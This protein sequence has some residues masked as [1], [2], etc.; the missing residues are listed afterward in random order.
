MIINDDGTLDDDN[1]ERSWDDGSHDEPAWSYADPKERVRA[2]EVFYT[3]KPNDDPGALGRLRK[4]AHAHAARAI[5]ESLLRDGYFVIKDWFDPG[6]CEYCGCVRL[7]FCD[8]KPEGRKP[9]A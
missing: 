9:L 8:R 5:A 1:G 2:V 3:C 7:V 6:S 4:E